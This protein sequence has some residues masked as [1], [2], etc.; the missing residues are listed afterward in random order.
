[1]TV[2]ERLFAA[3]A[4]PTEDVPL[5][6]FRHGDKGSAAVRRALLIALPVVLA[7]YALLDEPF[8][9][10]H[11]PGV[12][13]YFGEM[14]LALGVALAMLA[15]PHFRLV[16]R[17][18]LPVGLLLTFVAWGFV[19]TVPLIPNYGI[20]AVRDAAL[21]YYALAAVVV[22]TL[23]RSIP[24]LPEDWVRKYGALVIPLLLWSPIAML[25]ARAV[26]GPLIPDSGV[27]LFTHRPGNIGVTVITAIAFL[28]LVPRESLKPRSR[29]LLTVLATLVLLIV[30]TQNR[31]G[32]LAA[33]VALLVTGA[34]MRRGRLKMAAALLGTVLVTLT[35]A[36]SFDVRV[37]VGQGREVSVDQLW[38]NVAS[39]TQGDQASGQLGGDVQFRNELWSGVV[40]LAN[41]RSALLSGLGFGPNLAQEL[42]VSTGGVGDLRNPHNS[43]VD[44]LARMGVVGG[45]LWLAFWISWYLV[46]LRRL[47]NQ[48]APLPALHVGIVKVCLVAVTAILINAYFDPT[49]ETPQVALWLW[50]LVGLGLGLTLRQDR[51]PQE[52]QARFL[53]AGGAGR[54][55]NRPG[56]SIA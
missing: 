40:N 11:V 27:Q 48:R 31:A 52:A 21:W 3:E 26:G 8:A 7:G 2:N 33:A 15:T 42:G 51:A 46:L 45:I 24:G 56:I 36:W 6:G 4:P 9:N 18:S 1:M 43:H 37:D 34:L 49:L 19:R 17:R 53:Q 12:P 47:V 13:V 10:L 20:D 29:A 22:A 5:A 16:V 35:I 39:I 32:F 41:D 23:V 54:A 28:W 30:G 55:P 38:Q 44:V 14:V 50:T 25:L